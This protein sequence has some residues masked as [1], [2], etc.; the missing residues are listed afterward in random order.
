MNRAAAFFAALVALAVLF[1]L[2]AI[3]FGK[4]PLIPGARPDC[5]EPFSTGD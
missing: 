2:N 4:L 5:G 3:D 1:L